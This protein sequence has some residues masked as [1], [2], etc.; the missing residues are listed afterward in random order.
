MR[1]SQLC[2]TM[3]N[4]PEMFSVLTG[5]RV[6][7]FTYLWKLIV[8]FEGTKNGGNLEDLTEYNKSRKGSTW[9]K[10][11]LEL[12][13]MF[14]WKLKHFPRLTIQSLG[15]TFFS[16]NT[17]VCWLENALLSLYVWHATSS[18]SFSSQ[19]TLIQCGFATFS[20]ERAVH[21]L[22]P[23][24]W[25]NVHFSIILMSMLKSEEKNV[26]STTRRWSVLRPL[27]NWKATGFPFIQFWSFWKRTTERSAY[28]QKFLINQRKLIGNKK[29]WWNLWWLPNKQPYP[30]WENSTFE[31]IC[32]I[33]VQK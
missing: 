25:G 17:V 11:S 4:A 26:C 16:A 28:W 21:F 14:H 23:H 27:H 13:S 8:S 1:K 29:S 6:W 5:C 24:L 3:Q 15:Q 30:E 2:G 9:P 20:T 19:S 12:S 33:F 31:D 32:V 10:H 7:T 18:R 22:C